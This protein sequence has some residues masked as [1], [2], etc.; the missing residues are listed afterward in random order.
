M[1]KKRINWALYRAFKDKG[2]TGK[3]LCEKTEIDYDR[4]SRLINGQL[5]KW[6][7]NEMQIL[8]KVLRVPQ[9]ELFKT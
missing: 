4:F 1:E 7:T 2:Y 6:R 5:K 3:S 9:K 8:S